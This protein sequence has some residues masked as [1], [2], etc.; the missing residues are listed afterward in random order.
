MTIAEVV[1]V[2][3]PYKGGMGVVAYDNARMLSA[4]GHSV[5]VFTPRYNTP[6]QHQ[7]GQASVTVSWVPP[8]FSY[9][10]AAILP[11]LI[12]KLKDVDVIHLHYPFIGSSL[13]AVFASLVWRKPLVVTYHMNLA[14]SGALGVFF[15]LYTFCILPFVAARARTIFVTSRDYASFSP[16]KRLNCWKK[17]QELPLSV[18]TDRFVPRTDHSTIPTLLFVGGMDVPHAFKGVD[19]LLR[20]YAIVVRDAKEESRLCLVGDGELRKTYEE[21]ARELGIEKCVTFLGA[22]DYEDP[23]ALPRVMSESDVLILPSINRSEAFGLVLIEAMSCGVGVI[24]SNLPG[25]RS[26]VED[27]ITGYLVRPNDADDLAA[28]IRLVLNGRKALK[29]MGARGRK[30]VVENYS[31]TVIF[32]KF[33]DMML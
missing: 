15:S 8:F 7:S 10:N 12:W 31:H 2:Y 24:A 28:K 18:D 20:A 11:Q 29:E 9:G 1:A 25:V 21:L 17:I 14:G 27:G 23:D 3:P 26:V 30:R 22:L 19:V 33:I 13:V 16:L 5:S 32:K 4:A 6:S